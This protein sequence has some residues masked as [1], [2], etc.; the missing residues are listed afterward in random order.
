M[1]GRRL[2]MQFQP[3]LSVSQSKYQS[4]DI[5]KNYTDYIQP[6]IRRETSLEKIEN[7]LPGVKRQSYYDELDE[8]ILPTLSNKEQFGLHRPKTSL[9][10]RIEKGETVN[11]I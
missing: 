11:Q 5:V 4:I 7:Y 1:T 9:M 3:S 2:P 10:K 8:A 6:V